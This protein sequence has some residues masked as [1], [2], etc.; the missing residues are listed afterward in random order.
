M[1]LLGEALDLA[2]QLRTIDASD[3]VASQK[4]LKDASQML[5]QLVAFMPE[6]VR[7]WNRDVSDANR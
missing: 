6:L 4:A 3:V 5:E 1:S 2:Y 7:Q